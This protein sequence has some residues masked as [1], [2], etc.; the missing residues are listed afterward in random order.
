MI[1]DATN[2]SLLIEHLLAFALQNGIVNK[3]DT[4]FMRN[5]LM[6]VLCLNEPQ[7]YPPDLDSLSVP[8]TATPILEAMLE[9]ACKN[10]LLSDNTL[11]SKDLFD[12]AIMGVLMPKPS[13]II[14]QFSSI[15]NTRGTLAATEFFYHICRKCDYIRVDRIAKNIEWQHQTIYG[16][17]EITINLTKPE[18]DPAEIAALKNAPSIDYPKCLLCIENIGYAGR[19]NFPARQT[20]RALPVSLNKEQWHF[21]FSPYVYYNHHCIVFSEQHVPMKITE[22]TFVRLFDFLEQFPHYFIGSNAGLPIV[23]GSILNH[24]HF[25]GGFHHMPMAKAPVEHYFFSEDFPHV[26]IG[27]IK[28]PMAA[29]RLRCAESKHLIEF[30][31]YILKAWESYSDPSADVYAFSETKEGSLI[32]HNAVTP[33]AR[34]T[35]DGLFEIDIVFRNNRTS[36]EH[37]MGIFHPHAELHHI[38]KENIGLIEVMGLFILPGRLQTELNAIKG[39]LSRKTPYETLCNIT[40]EHPLQ[41]HSLWISQLVSSHGCNL[42]EA[43]ADR[44][45]RQAVGEKCLEVLHHASVFKD[46]PDGKKAFVRFL[47]AKGL[48]TQGDGSFVL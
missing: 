31:A 26:N 10:G 9:Y 23:G 42:N 39:V 19:S 40:N 16:N 43:N 41:K 30:C 48:I 44:V 25:Q 22:S 12:T 20:L 2:P 24:D 46:T 28:W 15:K 35:V 47:N 8:E 33:I 3:L 13:E 17:L 5:R 45:I 7:P 1:F 11:T 32:L 36:D 6:E 27:I 21:Q 34:R 4:I 38:K 14:Q 37:P 29:L 18:K